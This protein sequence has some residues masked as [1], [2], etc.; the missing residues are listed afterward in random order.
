V[1]EVWEPL[2]EDIKILSHYLSRHGRKLADCTD[3]SRFLT[4]TEPG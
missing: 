3:N 1:I 4:F 2:R